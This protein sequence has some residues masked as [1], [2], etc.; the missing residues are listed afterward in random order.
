MVDNWIDA[1]GRVHEDKPSEPVLAHIC[2]DVVVLRARVEG[3][4]AKLAA[5]LTQLAASGGEK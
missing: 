5:V 4:E 1:D 2:E 3:L